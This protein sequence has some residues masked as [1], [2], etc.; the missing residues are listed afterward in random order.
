MFYRS[1]VAVMAHPLIV[2]NEIYVGKVSLVC[3]RSSIYADNYL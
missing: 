3:Y 2:Y 1:S